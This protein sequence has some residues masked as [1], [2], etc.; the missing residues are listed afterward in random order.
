MVVVVVVVVVVADRV[1]AAL[2]SSKHQGYYKLIEYVDKAKH[3]AAI[4]K[5]FCLRIKKLENELILYFF[6]IINCLIKFLLNCY[7][8]IVGFING[9]WSI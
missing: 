2:S 9:Q 6:I 1:G 3:S 5:V 7:L 8:S 4:C